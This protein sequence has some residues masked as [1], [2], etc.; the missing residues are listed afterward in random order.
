MFYIR[1][2]KNDNKTNDKQPIYS[3]S[4]F[5]VQERVVLEPGVSYSV[6]LWRDEKND[7]LNLRLDEKQQQMQGGGGTPV[8]PKQQEPEVDIPF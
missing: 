1:L 7:S 8:Q 2:F 5:T 4:N 3:N 6:G